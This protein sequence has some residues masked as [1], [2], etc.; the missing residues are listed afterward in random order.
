[1]NGTPRS[2]SAF[3]AAIPDEPAPMIAAVARPKPPD[4]AVSRRVSHR[5]IWG[6]HGRSPQT[7]VFCTADFEAT[8]RIEPGL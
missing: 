3:A 2:W 8:E 1:V 4:A 5:A 6:S 7:F